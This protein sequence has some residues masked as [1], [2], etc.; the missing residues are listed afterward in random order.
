MS[1]KNILFKCNT[2]KGD[3]NSLRNYFMYKQKLKRTKV[4]VY[5]FLASIALLVI[6]EFAFAIFFLR[7][8][9]LAGMV[10]VFG[11]YSWIT[12]EVRPLEKNVKEF[13]NKKQEINLT[14][15]GFTVTWTG[16]EPIEYNWSELDRVVEND[17]HFFIFTVPDFAIIM[18]KL[19]MKEYRVTE[20]HDLFERNV[21]LVTDLSD[22]KSEKIY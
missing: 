8:A 22:W 21:K 6:S 2:T 15:S 12:V 16:Y 1:E 9:G 10:V 14:D 20:I 18:P 19:E 3:Y 13:I 5:L 17:T 4:L 11:I 7:L